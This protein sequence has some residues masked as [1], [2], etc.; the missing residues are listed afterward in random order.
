MPVPEDIYYIKDPNQFNFYGN[1]EN[2][3]VNDKKLIKKNNTLDFRINS[4]NNFMPKNIQS[5]NLAIKSNIGP[6]AK[7][8]QNLKLNPNLN[9]GNS[10][11][12][13][14]FN[15]LVNFNLSPHMEKIKY[16][17]KNLEN[18]AT[19]LKNTNLYIGSSNDLK[20]FSNAEIFD[21]NTLNIPVNR[22][23]FYLFIFFIFSLKI[24]KTLQIVF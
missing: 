5:N 15:G 10:S 12:A 6:K 11:N 17:P 19:N 3:N 21:K 4:K 7:H 14:N 20:T 8:T 16:N 2:R 9:L 22:F 24:P 18:Y 1:N 23:C 13:L